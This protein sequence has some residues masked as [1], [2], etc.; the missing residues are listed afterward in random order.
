MSLRLRLTLLYIIL[1]GGTLLLIGALVYGL[2]S[3]ILLDQVDT[4]LSDAAE[5][6]INH[7]QINFN[8]QFDPRSLAN[9][10]PAENLIFQLWGNDR[11]LQLARPPTHTEP[12]DEIGRWA[13]EPVFRSSPSG[14]K[15]LRVLS[16]PLVSGRG[17]AGLLQVGID[18]SLVDLARRALASALALFTLLSVFLSGLAAWLV[19]GQALAPL[20]NVTRIAAQI[21]STSD[22][23]RRIPT[24]KVRQ[25]EIGHL[26]HAFNQTLEQLEKL[27]NTQRRFL[28]DVSHEL[29]TPLTVIKGNI[30]LLRRQKMLDEESLASI[31]AEVDR[32]TRM[33]GDLLLLGQIESGQ[34]PLNMDRVELDTV[35]LEV[36]QQMRMLAGER[37]HL[38]LAEIDQVQ[39]TGDRD[40]LK[41]VFL[42]LVGNAVQ[43]TPPGGMVT[44]ALRKVGEQAQ[45]TVS[46]TGAGIPAEDLPHIFERFY[47]GEKSRKRRH[48]GGFGLGLAIAYYIVRSHGGTIEVSSQE[49]E[50]TTFC[51]WLPLQ[52]AV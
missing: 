4:A 8:Y 39:V 34:M 33:V 50:G 24:R 18:I 16:V 15:L 26:I 47:R 19:T 6:I 12:L 13:T 3:V 29:R 51:V 30:S 22:L 37:L 20:E 1:L 44:L 43:Y 31:E 40:R 2:F 35:L 41:Q 48:S 14:G 32:L 21:T 5:H 45:L 52:P 36:F 11:R 7:L 49:S 38:R 9:Y 27:F 42:N 25:D 46:D 10:L 17:P 28:T 23:Q